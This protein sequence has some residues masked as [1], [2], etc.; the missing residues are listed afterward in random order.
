MHSRSRAHQPKAQQRAPASA[1]CGLPLT[2]LFG[3]RVLAHAN[4]TDVSFAACAPDY[5]SK[6]AGGV[7]LYPKKSAPVVTLIENSGAI[8]LGKTNIPTFSNDNTRANTSWAGPTLNA[9]NKAKAPG[10]SSSGTATAVAG[11]FAVWGM[12]EET[13]G[14]IQSPAASQSLVGIKTTFHLVNAAVRSRNFVH[15]CAIPHSLVFL[16][17][18]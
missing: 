18:S 16:C 13:G 7:N 2:A 3:G 9:V 14:S 10:A 5:T 8:I 17:C 4:H 12:A 1:A 15:G 6:A 11:G